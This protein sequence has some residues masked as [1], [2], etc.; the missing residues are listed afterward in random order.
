MKSDFCI[1]FDKILINLKH[2]KINTFLECI[3]CWI[4]SKR[5]KSA[6]SMYIAIILNLTLNERRQN[7]SHVSINFLYLCT[8][9]V[10]VIDLYM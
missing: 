1:P 4:F 7:M 10:S 5:H 6:K 3:F 2:A 9:P 8:E